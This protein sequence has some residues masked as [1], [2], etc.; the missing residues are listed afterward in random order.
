M[1][2]DLGKTIGD[3]LNGLLNVT[4]TDNIID[5]TITSVCRELLQ[6]NVSPIQ[7]N[8]LRTQLNKKLKEEKILKGA[9]KAKVVYNAV[10]DELVELIDPKIEAFT[11]K[12]NS[13]NV[14]VFVGLQGAGK[15]TNICKYANYY[16]KKGFK[17]GL[18][19]ADTSRAGAFDQLRQNAMKI[20]V[21]FYGCEEKDPVKVASTGV[22]KFKEQ[23]CELILV[24]T[25]GRHTQET[26]LFN[27][28]KDI[29]NAVSPNNIVFVM[30]AGIGQVAQTH[31][32]GFKNAVN[33]GSIILTKL[34]GSNK[35]G[36]AISSVASTHCPIEFVG[37]GE[38]MEDLEKFDAKRFINK[39]L[40][41]GDLAGLME[42]VSD[43]NIDEK[44]VIRKIEKGIYTIK[45]FNEQLH[46]IMA[47]GP[48]GKIMEMLPGFGNLPIPDENMFKKMVIVFD[49]FTRKELESDGTCFKQ[50]PTRM[51]RVAKGSGTTVKDVSTVLMQ[52]QQMASIMKKIGSQP[53]LLNFMN[54]DPSKMS[55]TE[56][57]KLKRQAGSMFS[58][59]F[60]NSLQG[61]FGA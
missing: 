43:L 41:K 53:G 5:E 23:K 32:E 30:D 3:T 25:S 61:Y 18:V 38:G 35:A 20:N 6:S 24:D 15:T 59:D 10:F 21:P 55:L 9:N 51:L 48:L 40:G 26:D 36:G 28:M 56:K 27:E 47:L 11:P 2:Y 17:T 13:T 37:V 1:I 12:K 46:Q 60:M 49:S 34:D 29:I 57:S 52:Y 39:I 31:A 8:Y 58:K 4:I 33:V 54:K 45:D 50:Q 42:K 44:E 22:E 16:K 19:C 14:V 7:V